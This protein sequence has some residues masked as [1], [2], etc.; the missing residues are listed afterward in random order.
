MTFRDFPQTNVRGFLHRWFQ[1]IYDEETGLMLP[2]GLIKTTGYLILFQS[3]ATA[4][5]TARLEGVWPMAEPEI[6]ID[7]GSGEAMDIA[8]TL[9]VD[10]IIWEPSLFNPSR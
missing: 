4:E 5:R 1:L 8:V 3:D 7:Y 6:A 9:S 10:R 2:S